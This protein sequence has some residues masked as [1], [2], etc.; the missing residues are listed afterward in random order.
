MIS[1]IEVVR[2]ELRTI[3]NELRSLDLKNEG[4]EEAIRG[5]ISSLQKNT[6]IHVNACIEMDLNLLSYDIQHNVNRI[7]QEAMNNIEHH[8]NA[9]KVNLSI[10]RED[11]CM[12][13]RI[14]DNG[15]GFDRKTSKQIGTS[16][17]GLISMHERAE[18]MNGILT[19]D[20]MLGEG[21]RIKVVIPYNDIE[22][23]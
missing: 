2:R 9:S 23:D 6:N 7:I 3:I 11:D 4:L 19:I 12:V 18:S 14:E 20:S 16:S 15:Q 1:Q 10:K 5:H 8:A 21:T 13:I 22:R 17:F